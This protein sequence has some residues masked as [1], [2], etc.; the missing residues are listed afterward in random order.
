MTLPLAGRRLLVTGGTGF[1][2]QHLLASLVA[3]GA[4]VVALARNEHSLAVGTQPIEWVYLQDWS[5]QSLA[6]RVDDLPWDSIVN[7]AA[8]GVNPGDRDVS[9][10]FK[11]NTDCA[12]ALAQA[13]SRRSAQ[14]FVQIGTCSEYDCF[15]A[16]QPITELAPLEAKKLYGASKAAASLAASAICNAGGVPYTTARLFNVFGQG[17]G[18]HRLLP[19]LFRSLILGERVNLSAGTQLRDFCHV[20]DVAEAIVQIAAVLPTLT[21]CSAHH[22]ICTGNGTSVRDFAILVAKALGADERLLNFGALPMRPDD[23]PIVVGNPEQTAAT[24]NWRARRDLYTGILES[25]A[26]L[27]I[28]HARR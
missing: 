11:I 10:M 26:F 12:I 18:P 1:F 5:P 20:N 7:A 21:N 6:E 25:V 3:A 16:A 28:Q 24:F 13:A 2:G 8:Y 4:S 15:Q 27:K 23:V 9:M 19:S 22:N 14:S 17:E